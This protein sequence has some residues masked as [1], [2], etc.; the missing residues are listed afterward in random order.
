MCVCV[1]VCVCVYYVRYKQNNA[2]DIVKGHSPFLSG[3]SVL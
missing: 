2:G 3:N 1:C